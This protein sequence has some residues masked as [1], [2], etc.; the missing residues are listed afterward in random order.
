[1]NLHAIVSGAIGAVNP[2][3]PVTVQVSTGSTT[4][5]GGTRVPTYAAPV[6]ASG[7]VQPVQ[8]NDIAKLNGLNIQG[9][10]NKIYLSGDWN[11]LVRS[12]GKGGDLITMADGSV[13]LV[14]VVLENW[15]D[16]SSLAVTL[17]NGA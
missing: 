14:A 9:V 1:M 11:A 10:R 8:Y 15:P 16:W 6:A 17:Q 2:H 3:V 13:W 5:P 12:S 4:S 7:Q